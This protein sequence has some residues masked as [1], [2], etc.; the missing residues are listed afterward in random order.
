MIFFPFPY[1][2]LQSP[3]C[4]VPSLSVLTS[5]TPNKSNLF[6]ANSL[7]AAVSGPALYRLLTLQVHNRKFLFF[8]CVVALLETLPPPENRVWEQIISGLLLTSTDLE[9]YY[10]QELLAP[11]PKP[12]LKDLPQSAVRCRTFNLF[13][14]PLHTADPPLS[15]TWGRAMPRWQGT[16]VMEQHKA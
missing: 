12:K 8:C 14:A 16:T 9:F 6:L 5:C 2:K 10:L 7:A 1:K 11:R 15:T 3:A 13:T 4:T